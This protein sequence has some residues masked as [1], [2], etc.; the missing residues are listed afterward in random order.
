[1][2]TDE[3]SK[4]RSFSSSDR[5]VAEVKAAAAFE[6]PAAARICSRRG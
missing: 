6:I 3:A 1:M 2:P 4:L 5:F